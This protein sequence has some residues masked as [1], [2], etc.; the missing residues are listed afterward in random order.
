MLE[1]EGY[2]KTLMRPE[3]RTT[4]YPGHCL[5]V[6]ADMDDESVHMVLTDPPYFLD[7]LDGNWR[8]G[9]GRPP[10]GGAVGGLPVGMKFDPNQGR[11]FQRFIEPVAAHLLRILA[12][13]GFLL[14]F[15]SPRL[16][17]RAA[18]AVEDAGFEIRDQYA[19]RYTKR[20]QFKAFTMNHF[21][22]KRTDISKT[23]KAS[24]IKELDGRKTAQLR[25]QF[26][27]ILCAQKPRVGTLVDNWLKHGTGLIDP[28]QL[29]AGKAPS[30]IMTV[31]KPDKA[32]YNCHLTPK[33]VRVC[34]HLIRLFTRKHQ[35]V[36]DPFVGSGTTCVAARRSGRHSIGIDV[37]PEY[38]AIAKQRIEEA[39]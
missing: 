9:N 34:E 25:P 11:E 21:V 3:V 27:S 13:G 32:S 16:Y 31:E 5:D 29:L 15:S 35:I 28:K 39:L 1:V 12:P 4:L 33:P 26:E 2:A 36:I 22:E 6:L 23:R 30:T 20:A 37:N 10:T 8:K 19:W 7:G 24:I 14:M 18:V 38:I 17:H